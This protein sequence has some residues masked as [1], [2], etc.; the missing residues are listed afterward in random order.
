MKLRLTCILA[1]ICALA[2]VVPAAAIAAEHDRE[3]S[4]D[5]FHVNDL[6]SYAE[7][8]EQRL[9]NASVNNINPGVNGSIRVHGWNN[10][11]VQVKACIMTAAETD[12]QARDLVSQISIV[13]GPGN[14]EASGPSNDEHQNWSVS[15]D[16][17]VPMESNLNLKAHNGSLG[18][19]DVHGQIRFDTLNGSVR[20]NAVSGDVEGTTTNGSVAID[21]ANGNWSGKGMHVQ[22]TNGSVRLKLPENVSAHVEASTVNGS[23]HTDFPATITAGSRES[24]RHLSLD[25]GSGGPTIEATTVNGSVHITRG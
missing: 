4:A 2:T 20:L 1:G 16:V 7:T 17:W 18:V 10:A 21:V 3:C 11:D 24:R 13:Q 25:L 14:I 8:K 12:Q 5:H 19:D 15:Y 23:V 22:T 9:A 6:A